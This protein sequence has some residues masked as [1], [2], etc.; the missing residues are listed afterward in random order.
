MDYT[1][2]GATYA[3][4]GDIITIII[5][6]IFGVMIRQFLFVTTDLNFTLFKRACVLLMIAA[7]SN[8]IF[9]RLSHMDVEHVVMLYLTRSIYNV[10]LIGVSAIFILYV[11][12]LVVSTSR[13]RKLIFVLT[14][15]VVTIAS[16]LCVTTHWTHFGLYRD[17]KQGLWM[18]NAYLNPLAI[19]YFWVVLAMIVMLVFFHKR[20]IRQ[21]NA[22]LLTAG[23]LC[24]VI[25]ILDNISYGS[26]Y[27]T[28]SF[29]LPM[30]C[31]LVM[32]H[33]RPYDLLTGA[34]GEEA[35]KGIFINKKNIKKSRDYVAVQL[36]INNERDIPR[37]VGRILYLFNREYVTNSV[38]FNLRSG[39]YLGV[40]DHNK[41]N[42]GMWE[43]IHHWI[44]QELVP[45][46]EKY[47]M[48]YKVVVFPGMDFI[49]ETKQILN[50]ID[51]R[52]KKMKNKGIYFMSNGDIM[53]LRKINYIA[54]EL[55]DIAEKRNLNDPR[56]LVYAQ[57]VKNAKTG[58][59]NSAEC[60]MRMSLPEMKIVFPD[61]FI[62]T[63]ERL[64]VIHVLSMI[65]LNKTCQVVKQLMEEGY[66]FRRISVNFSI[67]EFKN[68]DFCDNV[69]KII[70]DNGIPFEKIAMELTESTN[71]DDYGFLEEKIEILQ[72][73]GIRMY[74]DDFGTGY[75][76]F[77]RILSLGMDVIKFD[78][79]M[80]LMLDKN[81][82]IRF[83][84]NHFSSAFK[85]M[86]YRILFEGVETEEQEE[87]CMECQADYLQGFK[88]SKPVP[89][90]QLR[91]F[92]QKE[93]SE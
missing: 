83:T 22:V 34:M 18:R 4:S 31:V 68:N 72:Q 44:Y 39:L 1:Q 9:Y 59:Y 48:D 57:P 47:N 89:W 41:I 27:L 25:V 13:Y 70:E 50:Y 24:V 73:K 56:I 79:S 87:I 12:N 85:D 53:E 64:G 28:F 74:L 65:I 11:R 7:V 43:R 30:I 54:S 77:D 80:L 20:M 14:N 6:L 37:P 40:M 92:F 91:D 81:E 26:T 16:I 58:K 15:C 93:K 35:F 67:S 78:R 90:E 55:K 71:D 38:V 52:L 75:S 36:A 69:I 17:S 10:C 32:I 45:Y 8:I 19:V 51:L 5:L 33:S 88:Y 42:E 3:S 62:P 84:L 2:L 60:L 21:I 66:D 29:L 49:Y 76:N 46:C 61:L 86:D 63:A 23:F 82:N